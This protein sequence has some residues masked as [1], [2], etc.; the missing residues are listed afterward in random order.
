MAFGYRGANVEFEDFYVRN[1]S[2]AG[3][4]TYDGSRWSYRQ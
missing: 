4:Y 2:R 3:T 1:R